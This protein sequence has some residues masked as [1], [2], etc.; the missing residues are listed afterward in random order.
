MIYLRASSTF[1][2]LECPVLLLAAIRVTTR[3]MR[4]CSCFIASLV[5]LVAT[6]FATASSC[7]IDNRSAQEIVKKLNLTA[8]VEKG[9]FI[10]TFEDPYTIPCLNRSASTA[11][12]YLLQ[13]SDGESVWH[14]V[15]EVEIWHHYAGAPLVLELSFNDGQPWQNVTLGPDIFN[16]Q[17]PQFA[18]P[19]GQWQR[20]RSLGA[21]TLV[22]TTVA[23]GFV[24]ETVGN[25]GWNPS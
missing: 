7:S 9:Y 5:A 13:G 1:L 14:N 23:P 10:Q 2:R 8:N 4:S 24:S 17:Q 21:W 15:D 20:A 3:N 12:Y 6:V 22:G 19:K 16:N 25:P 18:I 11:I